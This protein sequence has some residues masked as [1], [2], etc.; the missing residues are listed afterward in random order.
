[1]PVKV[2]SRLLR[3]ALLRSAVRERLQWIGSGKGP[4]PLL[5]KVAAGEQTCDLR[6]ERGSLEIRREH[7]SSAQEQGGYVGLMEEL[8]R[9]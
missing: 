1:M 8:Q 7:E 5:K 6:I 9:E 2:V 4:S 3:G